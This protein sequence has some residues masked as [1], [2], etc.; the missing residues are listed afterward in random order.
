MKTKTGIIILAI[1]LVF[2]VA[3]IAVANIQNSDSKTTT[4]KIT[5][6]V[7]TKKV[8]TTKVTISASTREDLAEKKVLTAALREMRSGYSSS[9]FKKYDVDSTRYKIGK[10]ERKGDRFTFY[11]TFYLYDNYGNYKDTIQ[12]D[13]AVDVDEY[14]NVGYV[15]VTFYDWD[16]N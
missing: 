1:V 11:I 5:T 16:F 4:T 13:I 3:I 2:I 15:Y 6:T 10:V 8:T 12:K 7:S 14:G 9:L